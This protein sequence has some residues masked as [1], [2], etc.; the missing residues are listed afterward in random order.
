MK[1]RESFS[2]ADFDEFSADYDV[3]LA[4]GLSVSGEGK[5]YFAR[6]RV[7]W[8]AKCLRRMEKTPAP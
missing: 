3:A 7:A 5:D 6:G 4:H 1:S 2:K 8:V